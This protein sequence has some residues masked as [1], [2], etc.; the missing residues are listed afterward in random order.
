MR[1]I[2]LKDYTGKYV[3]VKKNDDFFNF[4]ETENIDEIKELKEK[5][6]K[7]YGSYYKKV[8]YDKAINKLLKN[9]LKKY[10]VNNG[11]NEMEELIDFNSDEWKLVEK[12]IKDFI[13]SMKKIND[14]YIVD[15]DVLIEL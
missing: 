2:K 7:I 8:F 12:S 10:A 9:T 6:L 3:C 1:T 15:E 13:D 11:Y 4:I 14:S 5:G